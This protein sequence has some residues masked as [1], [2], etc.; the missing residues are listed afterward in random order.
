MN[1]HFCVRLL[2]TLISLSI[3]KQIFTNDMSKSTVVIV[4]IEND[5][6]VSETAYSQQIV[7]SYCDRFIF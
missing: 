1:I 7:V 4:E 3:V 6:V 2:S 5:M